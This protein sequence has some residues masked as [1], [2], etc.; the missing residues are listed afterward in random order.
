MIR[1]G[2]T[3]EINAV[4]T[5]VMGVSFTLVLVSQRLLAARDR[6]EARPVAPSPLRP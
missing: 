6:T 5:I 2:V 1:F 3:P 4:A